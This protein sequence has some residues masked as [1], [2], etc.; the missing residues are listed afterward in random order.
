MNPFL[1]GAL[2][3]H[4]SSKSKLVKRSRFVEFDL[5][6]AAQPHVESNPSADRHSPF[7]AIKPR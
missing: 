4:H 1:M 3:I 2:A 5:V 7:I 6:A